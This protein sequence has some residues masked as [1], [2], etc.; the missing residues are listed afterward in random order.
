MSNIYEMKKNEITDEILRCTCEDC[1]EILESE[2]NLNYVC[3]DDVEYQLCDD[4][5]KE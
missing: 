2:S 3:T 4:C 5:N 1:G